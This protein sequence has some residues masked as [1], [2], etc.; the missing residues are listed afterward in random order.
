MQNIQSRPRAQAAP[1]ADDGFREFLV[2]AIRCGRLRAQLLQNELDEIGL[3]LKAGLV[4]PDAAMS[5]LNDI[6]GFAFLDVGVDS[7]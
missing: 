4:A 7:Q 3:A 1:P 5:W 6:G 2:A